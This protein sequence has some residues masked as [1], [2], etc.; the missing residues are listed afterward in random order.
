MKR[1]I[2]FKFGTDIED[3]A[4]LLMD[5]KTTPKWTWPGSRDLIS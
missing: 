1:A 2:R 5:Y 3:A 4:S